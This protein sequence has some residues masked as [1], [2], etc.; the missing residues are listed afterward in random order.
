MPYLGNGCIDLVAGQLSALA[1]LGSLCHLYLNDIG[2]DQVFRGNPET[3]GGDLL[4]G[5]TPRVAVFQCLEA[6]CELAAFAGIGFAANAVHGNRQCRVGLVG[7][8]TK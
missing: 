5:R 3:S 4:D 2:V 8:G 7:N 6:F 1:G